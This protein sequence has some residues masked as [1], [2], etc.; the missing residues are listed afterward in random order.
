MSIYRFNE[1]AE[2]ATPASAKA[3]MFVDS[4]DRF[5]KLKDSKGVL[6]LVGDHEL[7]NFVRNSGFWFA[8][9]QAP[10][11]L[12]TYSNTSG[13]AISAD[14]FG[15]TNENASVQYIRVDT[16]GG[17]ETGLQ[18]RYYGTFSK[19]TNTGKI[20]VSQVLEGNDAV[21]LRGRTVRLQAWIKASGAMTINLALVQLTSAGTLDTIP[22]TFISAFGAAATDPT[23]GTNL[24]YIAPKSTVTPD[25]GTIDG[26]H[27]EL[28][29]TTAWQRVGACFDVPAGAKNLVLMIYSDGQVTQTTGSFSVSQVSLTDGYEIQN[30]APLD[31]GTELNRVQRFYEKTFAI[32]QQPTTAVGINTGEL[33]HVAL[34]NSVVI[35]SI[36]WQFKVQK[37]AAPGTLTTYSPASANAEARN[38][39]DSAD[40]S[41]TSINVNGVSGA[42]IQTTGS[43]AAAIGE[44]IGVHASVDAEL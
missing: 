39:T 19:I 35:T 13:R 28:A 34:G 6:G 21:A 22:S 33:K 11:T 9:R 15:I 26:N 1:V 37:R 17:A 8:Q 30:W 25:N 38:I 27:V 40:C 23:L 14:G 2:P 24:S 4:A 18:G 7:P 29:A 31:Y 44:H 20:I 16:S 32:D 3:D 5:L 10:G 12:T 41:S 42:R 43:A 36:Y